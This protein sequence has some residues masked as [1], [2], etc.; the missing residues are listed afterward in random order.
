MARFRTFAN[1]VKSYSAPRAT[2][3]RYRNIEPLYGEKCSIGTDTAKNLERR[4]IWSVALTIR[5]LKAE[6]LDFNEKRNFDRANQAM[7]KLIYC[8]SLEKFP[9]ARELVVGFILELIYKNDDEQLR[10]QLH[11]TLRSLNVQDYRLLPPELEEKKSM[12]T[13]ATAGA[14]M[15]GLAFTLPFGV[16]PVL[17]YSVGLI[18]MTVEAMCLS[19][20]VRN[21]N[22]TNIAMIDNAIEFLNN[23]DIDTMI[24][25]VESD[26]AGP[27]QILC[28][29]K[30]RQMIDEQ[31]N[32]LILRNALLGYVTHTA[33]AIVD[34]GIMVDKEIETLKEGLALLGDIEAARIF[35]ETTARS[36][37][38]APIGKEVYD[39]VCTTTG[40]L[41]PIVSPRVVIMEREHLVAN[42]KRYF[43][44]HPTA[45][46]TNAAM[47]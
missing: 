24:G 43:E 18:I 26:T 19:L 36:T 7:R 14:T 12:L 31:P 9:K 27:G 30:L 5:R 11:S 39:H 34:N 4:M 10:E 23:L 41:F 29:A 22:R 16:L 42:L 6:Y 46:T 32:N 45:A 37:F 28:A 13:Y 40:V 44:S 8:A 21:T 38:D 17:G 47:N 20:A 25:V 15:I 1:A 35:R 2:F 3:G 33:Q